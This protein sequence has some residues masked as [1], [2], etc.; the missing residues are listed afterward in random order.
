MEASDYPVDFQYAESQ[1]IFEEVFPLYRESS[2]AVIRRI[3][4]HRELSG[5]DGFNKRLKISCGLQLG[6]S[7][8]LAIKREDTRACYALMYRVSD[9]WYAFEQL[10]SLQPEVI[11]KETNSKVKPYSEQT[12]Q[13]VGLDKVGEHFGRLVHEHV[14]KESRWRREVYPLLSYFI[15]NTKGGT[16]TALRSTLASVRSKTPLD[17]QDLLALCYGMRNLYVHH[18]VM[19]AL[20]TRDYALKR[21]L[22]GAMLDGLTLASF[23]AGNVYA[24]RV[25]AL[26]ESESAE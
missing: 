4:D 3:S 12:L 17:I 24:E 18:G 6:F 25:L 26:L 11:P 19:A 15:N 9:L 7:D 20:G 2:L 1:A 22:Y 10:L 16:K 8:K 13:D 5:F 14:T 21:R 23:Q